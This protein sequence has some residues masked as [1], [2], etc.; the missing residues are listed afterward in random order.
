MIFARLAIEA[1]V[2]VAAG[3]LIENPADVTGLGTEVG[4]PLL[5]KAIHGGGGRGIRLVTDESELA[6]L[7]P[8]AALEAEAAF[9]NGDLYLERYYGS[10]RHVEVHEAADTP[11][12]GHHNV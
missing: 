6:A 9:G 11:H 4:F 7:A 8:Q 5:I 12:L 3:R 2:P 1:G 10:A